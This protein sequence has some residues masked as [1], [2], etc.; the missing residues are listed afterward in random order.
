MSNNY[1]GILENLSGTTKKG[2][3]LLQN[4]YV[5]L[6]RD[7]ISVTV[8]LDTSITSMTDIRLDNLIGGVARSITVLD[9]GGGL[10]LQTSISDPFIVLVG[11]SIINEDIERLSWKGA[12]TG[13][14]IIRITGLRL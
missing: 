8:N 12:G 2:L 3:S 13:T 9:V 14:A 6:K 1:A 7:N 5:S 10:Y 4:I 11:D